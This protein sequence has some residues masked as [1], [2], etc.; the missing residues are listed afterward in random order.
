MAARLCGTC[1]R[2]NKCISPTGSMLAKRNLNWNPDMALEAIKGAQP[3]L[4]TLKK[5]SENLAF[6]FSGCPLM[7]LQ[8]LGGHKDES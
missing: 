8:R 4:K 3:Q 5:S 1:E 7:V 6:G 2:M